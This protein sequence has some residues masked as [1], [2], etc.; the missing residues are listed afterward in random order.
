MFTYDDL[1]VRYGAA[2]A[3][4]VLAEIEKA[5][6]L[7][8]SERGGIDP[9]ARLLAAFRAQDAQRAAGSFQMSAR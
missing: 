7:R 3:Y 4:H 5:A 2:A 8:P 1:V 6:R 9:E